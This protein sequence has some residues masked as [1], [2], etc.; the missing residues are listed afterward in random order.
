MKRKLAGM[1][2]IIS[3]A[4]CAKSLWHDSGE[5][6]LDRKSVNVGDMIKI[7]F[8]EKLKLEYKSVSTSAKA[9]NKSSVGSS[10]KLLEFLPKLNY[11]SSGSYENE[12]EVSGSADFEGSI[13][14]EVTN[15]LSGGRLMVFGKH[16]VLI[17]D[18]KEQISISGLVDADRLEKGNRI[19]STEV[20]NPTITYSGITVYQP[21]RFKPDDI[22]SVTNFTYIT[23]ITAA[24]N[25]AGAG[26]SVTNVQTNSEI[27]IKI[28]DS[29]EQELI[30]KEINKVLDVLFRY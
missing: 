19:N 26:F 8:S 3:M 7:I 5:M 16:T 27:N 25:A 6:F 20:L 4:L 13:V 21:D 29:K 1:F 15:V 11:T 10:S 24:T 17:N 18:E 22:I 14:V 9:K 23:N 12:N 30:L 28:R 2:I